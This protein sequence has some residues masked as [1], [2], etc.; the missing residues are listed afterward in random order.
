S[1]FDRQ[2]AAWRESVLPKGLP[3]VSVEAGITDFWRKYV[4]LDGAAIG[5]D[6]FGESAPAAEVYRH[7]G[8]TADA[9]AAAVRERV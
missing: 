6:R 9:V 7:F 2:D 5:V 8:V 3:R 4:G 1:V